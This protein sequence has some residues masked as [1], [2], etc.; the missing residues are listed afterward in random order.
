M[1]PT[2]PSESGSSRPT[3]KS[4]SEVRWAGV[5]AGSLRTVQVDRVFRAGLSRCPTGD[6]AWWIIDYK[7]AHADTLAPAAALPELRELFAPQLDTYAEVLRNLHGSD[8]A[9]RAGLYYPR[10]LLFDWWEI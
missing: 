1:P 2:T 9:I 5:V 4:S 7:T 10:M 8:A 6:Q 3:P